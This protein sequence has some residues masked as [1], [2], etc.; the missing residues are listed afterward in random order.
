MGIAVFAAIT[1]FGVPTGLFV[2]AIAAPLASRAVN[3]L[4]SGAARRTRL[5]MERQLPAAIDLL[6]AV[7]DAGRPPVE[8]FAMVARATG[9]PLGPEFALIAGRL[10]IAGDEQSVWE[11]LRAT[12]FAALGRAFRRAGRSGMPV[13]RILGRFAGEL[14][15]E[16]RAAGQERAR[17]VAVA[18]AAPLGACFLPAFFLIGILPTIIGAFDSLPL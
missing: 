11:G 3:R 9:E 13:G 14:R 8:A 16:R 1:V 6:A 4:E 2:A 10:S 15:R 18:T 17:S 7:L 5:Q 12:E